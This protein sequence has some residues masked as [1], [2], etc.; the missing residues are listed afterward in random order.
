[1]LKCFDSWA[2]CLRQY[3]CGSVLAAG[4]LAGRYACGWGCLQALSVEQLIYN[5]SVCLF[6]LYLQQ[7]GNIDA[8]N[9]I[10]KPAYDFGW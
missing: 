2:V 9:F 4:M 1:M 10:R 6:V 3:A 7:L 8:Y 5:M